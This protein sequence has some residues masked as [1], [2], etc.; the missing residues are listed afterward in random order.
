MD[1]TQDVISV[2]LSVVLLALLGCGR[3]IGAAPQ[4]SVTQRGSPVGGSVQL[5]AP[6]VLRETKVVT[7]GVFR[8]GSQFVNT[9]PNQ[10]VSTNGNRLT[11]ASAWTGGGLNGAAYA[12]YAFDSTGYTTDDTLHLAWQVPGANFSDL[13]IGLANFTR[14]RW[15]WFAGPASGALPYDAAKY[16][17]NGQVYAAV[18]CL[19]SGAWEL[20]SIRISLSA[21][22][23]VMSVNPLNCIQ[24]EPAAFS[25]VIQGSAS[26]YSWDFGGGAIPNTSTAS[27]PDVTAAV[28]GLYHATLAVA[29]A[30][31]QDEFSFDL[32]V[33]LRQLTL[34]LTNPPASGAGT[35]INPYQANITTDYVFQLIESIDGNVSTS[36]SSHY[37]V[38]DEVNVG[39]IS[40]LDAALNISD[41]FAGNFSVT[42]DYPD[43]AHAAAPTL[44]F[45]VEPPA[46]ELE[47]YPDPADTDWN[48]ATG[49][50]T[51][52]DP[53]M[54][55]AVDLT[56]RYSMLADDK[57]GPGGNPIPVTGL[58]W[59]AWPPFIAT[60]VQP[61]EFCA[62]DFAN[63]Y[64]YAQQT[65]SPAVDSNKVYFKLY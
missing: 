15:D 38:S 14:D 6:S 60:W 18:L 22:P 24:G 28:T 44:Y 39:V 52:A 57:L 19:G 7:S 17:A 50:G 40:N 42:A 51:A 56:R 48:V 29:N 53:Y 8:Y 45:T 63:G 55:D 36:P 16:T 5:P 26:S 1:K 43:A 46:P 35:L 4:P 21:P 47:I 2:V 59:D 49:S 25:A 27:A 11:F 61:G 64:L 65:G 32:R 62:N 10:L 12:I 3:G 20:S 13:W 37:H 9:L 54:L 33:Y 34:S 23:V 31:G 58:V 41:A 30:Y